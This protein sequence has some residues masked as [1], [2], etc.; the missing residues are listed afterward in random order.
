MP[1]SLLKLL[2]CSQITIAS[3]MLQSMYPIA[4]P[5]SHLNVVFCH[6]R[7]L[8]VAKIYMSHMLFTICLN[9]SASLSD[10]YF[11]GDTVYSRYFQTKIVR[12]RSKHVNIFYGWDVNGL[13]IEFSKQTADLVCDRMLVW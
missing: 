7:L 1:Q 3:F 9:S 10:I 8:W 13:G 2:G 5:V 6:C 11:T 12:G 4:F